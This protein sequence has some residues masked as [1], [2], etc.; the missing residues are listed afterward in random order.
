MQY[1]QIHRLLEYFFLN[2]Y[3]FFLKW[4]AKKKFTNFNKELFLTILFMSL[5]VYTRKIY[6]MVFFYLMIIFYFNLNK[7][8]LIQTF[9]VV[10]L[11]AIPGI[12][13]VLLWPRILEATFI[14][15]LQNSLLVNASIIS[16]YL[17]PF[18]L[19][20]Y[21][22][23]KKIKFEKKNLLPFFLIVI[24]VI[25][26][27]IFFNYNYLMGGGYFIKLSKILF[28][29][30]IIFY[31]TSIIGFFLLYYLSLE[32]MF[33][34]ILSLILLFTISAYIIFMKYY[35]PMF[36]ILLFLIYK[37]NYTNIFLKSVKNIYFFHLYFLIYLGTAIINSFLLFSKNI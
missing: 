9:F 22:F 3:I 30:F 28:D 16:F 21:F 26:C 5:T 18:Y 4:E 27:S 17:I 12:L 6:A 20:L 23:E 36:L 37:T 1:G 24:F 14:F 25:I 19:I 29:N 10:G 7:K 8:T 15:K 32:S 31:L 34:L 13:L 33:N 2:F 11:F 35:E